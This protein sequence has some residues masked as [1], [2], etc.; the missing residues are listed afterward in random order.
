MSS[1]LASSAS[2][3]VEATWQCK[4]L[5]A[6]DAF[7]DSRSIASATD[8]ATLANVVRHVGSARF[9]GCSTAKPSSCRCSTPCASSNVV[10]G[11][12]AGPPPWRR[13]RLSSSSSSSSRPVSLASSVFSATAAAVAASL[14]VP[15]MSRSAAR[16][17]SRVES[18]K[19]WRTLNQ[20]FG[21]ISS[22]SWRFASL[23]EMTRSSERAR[24]VHGC[25][26]WHAKLSA[27]KHAPVVS[28]AT[29]HVGASSSA[30]SSSTDDAVP[31]AAVP[32]V[33]G[34]S[35]EATPSRT[36]QSLV[37]KSPAR[38]TSSPLTKASSEAM[39]MVLAMNRD[40]TPLKSGKPARMAPKRS[41]RMRVLTDAGS[42]STSQRESKEIMRRPSRR[43]S[44]VASA[45]SS[46]MPSTASMRSNRAI[47]DRCS[48]KSVSRIVASAETVPTMLATRKMLHRT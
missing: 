20:S 35:I 45:T 5:S 26:S 15:A 23:R 9:D 22:S 21:K 36:M 18:S 39:A 7:E 31:A 44:L 48:A 8:A 17:T 4:A 2:S 1:N 11:M 3:P 28:V 13:P 38:D 33:A 43:Y 16:L 12:Y 24:T 27:P 29:A 41:V 47:R 32:K 14:G 42:A 34:T 19:F 46:E 40:E 6:C 37:A 25:V 10:D 30:S